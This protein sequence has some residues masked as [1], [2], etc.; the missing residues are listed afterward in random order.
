MPHSPRFFLAFIQ[1]PKNPVGAKHYRH[2]LGI[3]PKSPNGNAS[4]KPHNAETSDRRERRGFSIFGDQYCG[5]EFEY[6]GA[7]A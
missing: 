1:I 5:E 2:H 6:C 4:P 7:N 3:S